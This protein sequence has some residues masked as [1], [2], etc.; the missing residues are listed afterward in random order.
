MARAVRSGIDAVPPG[1]IEAAHALGFPE[2]RLVG[3][4]LLPQA[5]RAVIPTLGNLGVD[6]IKNTSICYA[7]SVVELTVLGLGVVLPET[8]TPS[9]RFAAQ[10]AQMKLAASL[11]S[12]LPIYRA[13]FG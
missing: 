8:S 11:I 6:L 1:Y 2:R 12:P 13:A 4:I 3:R 9:G 7:I 10:G 5:I